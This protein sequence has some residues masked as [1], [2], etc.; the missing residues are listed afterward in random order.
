MV[1]RSHERV[2]PQIAA[3]ICLDD[4][5]ADSITRNKVFILTACHNVSWETWSPEIKWFLRVG[6]KQKMKIR[7]ELKIL[8]REEVGVS[9]LFGRKYRVSM[10]RPVE[11]K[12]QG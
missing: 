6:P 9:V 5:A 1:A 12:M 10:R 11:D 7:A 8:G 2:V 3:D 4:F